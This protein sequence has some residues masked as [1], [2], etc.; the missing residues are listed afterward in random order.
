MK[1]VSSNR[2]RSSF[3][4]GLLICLI[5]MLVLTAGFIVA[6]VFLIDELGFAIFSYIFCGV[7][8]AIALFLL[9]DTLTN[10][11]V[12]E[13][14]EII[15]YSFLAKKRA[16]IRTITKIVHDGNFYIIYTNNKKFVSLND[17]DP[18]TDKMMYQFERWGIPIGKIEE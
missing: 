16:K 17:R 4:V 5:I 11:V 18:Q 2:I 7:F 6:T 8:H 3:S 10:Y 13:G 1:K 9:V 14:D 15:K 12:L